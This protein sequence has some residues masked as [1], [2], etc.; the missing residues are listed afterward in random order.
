MCL[1]I[2]ILDLLLKDSPQYCDENYPRVLF[3]PEHIK[4]LQS[5]SVVCFVFFYPWT[6]FDLVVQ[7]GVYIF[8][9]FQ[10][11]FRFKLY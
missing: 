5:L 9:V 8:A 7:T 4:I 11:R 2:L 6:E 1:S 10:D 3:S